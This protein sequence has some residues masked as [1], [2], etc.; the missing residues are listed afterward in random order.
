MGE[1][2]SRAL[3]TGGSGF[4]ATRLIPALLE[5]GWDVRALGRRPRP[6]W[7]PQAAAYERVDIVEDDIDHLMS[8]VDAVFHLAG[9]SSSFAGQEEM[10]RSNV[11]GTENVMA[12]AYAAQVPVLH[13][14]ST[15]VYGEEKALAQPVRETVEPSPSRGYGKAKWRAEQV[16]WGYVD[17]GYPAIILRPVSVY[18]PRNIK[19]LASA[20]LDTAI[21]KYAGLSTLELNRHP[22]DL[23]IVHIDDL[24]AVCL[25]LF[26][27]QDCFG[28][29]FNVTQPH[30][31]SSIEVAQILADEFRLE[32]ELVDE[33]EC[34]LPFEDRKRVHA[35]MIAAGMTN[36]IMLNEKRF[37]LLNKSNRNNRVSIE[38]LLSTGFEFAHDG[39]RAGVAR[40]T[41]W[42]RTHRWIM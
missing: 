24:V 18:G 15:S 29:A 21:E 8:D 26:G 4:I 35:D 3:V 31:P 17:K 39:L 30:Y 2:M 28:R 1:I 38:A 32:L 5:A 42:Y 19:L 33:T 41:D 25:H 37:R 12:T 9:L 14:S 27:R 22:L 7:I 16:V 20:I 13:M 23:R 11:Q 34:G 36:D 10:V 6:E 40:V